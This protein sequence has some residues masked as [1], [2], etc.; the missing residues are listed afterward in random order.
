[1]NLLTKRN[2]YWYISFYYTNKVTGDAGRYRKSSNLSATKPNK[3][4]ALRMAMEIRNALSHSNTTPK[5]KTRK[6]EVPEDAFFK[7][8]QDYMSTLKAKGL[9]KSTLKAYNSILRTHLL[10]QFANSSVSEM[11]TKMVDTWFS[12]LRSAKNTPLS[13]KTRN[14]IIN[15]L[16]EIMAKAVVWEH[17]KENP[18][19]AISRSKREDK[20][21][22]FW[23]KEERDT[24]LVTVSQQSPRFFPI[25][26]T[27]LFTGMRIGEILA[28]R[29]NHIDLEKGTIHVQKNFVVDHET[30]PKSGKTRII[31]I[32]QFLV[33]VLT[34][35]KG[36]NKKRALVFS[37]SNGSHLSNDVL[38]KPFLRLCAQANVKPIRMHDMRHTFASLAL[39]DGVDVPTVQKWL[40]H[41]DITTTMRYIK[42]LPDHMRQEAQKLNPNAS[43]YALGPSSSS[44]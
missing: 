6:Q 16:S 34:E 1:M 29:W 38:R 9:K 22:L 25:F 12:G 3:T 20:D 11:T 21:M 41:K 15:F 28:L 40:G 42:L 14:N 24:F 13:K 5:K 35:Y 19:K 27:F 36:S 4:E 37:R 26:A 10:P 2:G 7:I 17:C 30:S 33:E 43:L 23:S 44:S 32:C 39:M 8:A 31:Q 18:I